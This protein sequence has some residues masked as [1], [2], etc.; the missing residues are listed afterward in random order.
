MTIATMTDER[1]GME[2]RDLMA[3]RYVLANKYLAGN[4]SVDERREMDDLT[5]KIDEIETEIRRRKDTP[6]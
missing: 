2:W 4:A 3:R 1:L 5:Q 6:Q